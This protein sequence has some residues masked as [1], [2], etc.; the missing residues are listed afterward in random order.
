MTTNQPV[1]YDEVH[2]PDGTVYGV[3]TR[4][5]TLVVYETVIFG[6]ELAPMMV[7]EYRTEA[8]AFDS[9]TAYVSMIKAG[10]FPRE[11]QAGD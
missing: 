5:H 3:S 4:P 7:D 9:H 1:R 2:A 11:E 6:S 10:R 8:E